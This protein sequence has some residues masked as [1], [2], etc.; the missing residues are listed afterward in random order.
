MRPTTPCV[1]CQTQI[2]VGEPTC[3]ACGAVQ[4]RPAPPPAAAPVPSAADPYHRPCPRCGKLVAVYHR[5]CRN[6]GQHLGR[7]ANIWSAEL[8]PGWESSILPDGSMQLKRGDGGWHGSGGKLP[9]YYFVAII[10]LIL[11]PV[12]ARHPVHSDPVV[13]LAR[14]ACLLVVAV[15]VTGGLVWLFFGTERWRVAPDTIEIQKECL[16]H[17]WGRSYRR[18]E[19]LIRSKWRSSR[20]RGSSYPV[21]QL[22]VRER[23]RTHVLAETIVRRADQ[24]QALGGFLSLHSGWPLQLPADW[25]PSPSPWGWF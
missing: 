4:A 12:I 15:L 7:P 1:A 9:D 2:S 8:P 18:A 24:L 20:V 14:L 5:D 19:L 22:V 6:C 10:W 16:G 11:Q 21:C 23:G 3:W 17:R 25:P 13:E